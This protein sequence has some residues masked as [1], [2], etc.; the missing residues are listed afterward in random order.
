[1]VFHKSGPRSFILESFAF[2]AEAVFV[3]ASTTA[4][5]VLNSVH[6]RPAKEQQRCTI[7]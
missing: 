6:N 1:M 2:G 5:Q 7:H 3:G 4:K